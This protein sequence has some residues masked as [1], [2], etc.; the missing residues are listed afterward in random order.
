MRRILAFAVLISALGPP[1]L[2]QRT[3]GGIS[4]TVKDASGSVLPGVSV[5]V[6]GPNVVGDQT[7]TTNEHGF[8]RVLN[9]PPGEYQV[10]FNM[11]GFKTVTH[12]GIRVGLGSNLEQNASLEI[13]QLQESVDVTAEASVVDTTSSEVGSNFDRE[14]VENAPLRRFSFFDLVAAAPGAMQGGDGS[15]RTMMYGSGYD[16]N[17]FQVDGVDIT[18]NYFNE[19]LAEPNTDAIEEVEILALG[20]PAEYGNMTGAVYNIVTRQGTNAFHGDLSFFY[21]S[22][23]L[24]SDNT[25][26]LTNPDGAFT[27]ACSDDLRCPWTRDSYRDFSAQIGGPI[28]KDKLWFFGS[29]GYQRDSYWDIGVDPNGPESAFTLKQNPTDRYLGQAL[30]ADQLGPQAG[31]DVPLRQAPGGQRAGHRLDAQHRLVAPDEDADAGPR[32]HR[33]ALQ[34]RPSSTSAS[35]GSTATSPASPPTPAKRRASPGST[36]STRASSP[37]GTTTGT[38]SSPGAPRPPPRSPTSPTTSWARATTS[39]SACST[40]RRQAQGHLRLQRLR[41]HLQRDQPQ[42]RLRVRPDALQL[43]GRQPDGRR[44]H[45][46]HHQGE[47]PPLPQPRRALRLEQGLRRRPER[48]RRHGNP[49]GVTLPAGGL[50]HLEHDRRPASASTGS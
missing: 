17:A 48:G 1:L 3:T 20:A 22:D 2:A 47:R 40:A 18:D 32:V 43:H 6:S 14:F 15:A 42:L 46:R 33:R 19:A 23:G 4:G 21:Q 8:Y 37:A 49:T 11:T 5:A 27:D 44:L 29:Y 45:R 10:V 36:T 41:L 24:T 31:G 13:S 50:L 34:T 26:N 35:R 7:T 30:L 9:L 38:S 16:E 39:S 28:I 25:T 12:R